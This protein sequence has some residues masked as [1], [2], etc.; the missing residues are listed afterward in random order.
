MSSPIRAEGLT[1]FVMRNVTSRAAAAATLM[2]CLAAGASDASA[3]DAAKGK[4]TYMAIGCFECHGR[5]GPGGRLNYPAPPLAQLQLPAESLAAF[6][7]EGKGD[8]PPYVESQVSDAE[9]A[10]IQAF[11][12]TL[13]GPVDP[14]TIP[15]LAR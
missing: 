6:L 10:D 9:V 2:L 15:L 14:K 12:Q 8:M 3:A 5:S 13:R 7:R 1:M 4:E 11:L